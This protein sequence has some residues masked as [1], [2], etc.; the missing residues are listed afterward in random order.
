MFNTKIYI[1]Q[2]TTLFTRCQSCWIYTSYLT[3]FFTLFKVRIVRKIMFSWMAAES[4][5]PVLLRSDKPGL[6]QARMYNPGCICAS[7]GRRIT[8][9]FCTWET[10][11]QK[12]A[13]AS[14]G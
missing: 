6:L 5:R 13:E 4:F 10:K 11:V 12:N 8:T 2:E 9:A 1:K 14:S 3:F 7:G